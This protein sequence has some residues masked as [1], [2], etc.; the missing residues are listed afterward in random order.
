MEVSYESNA[1]NEDSFIII[2]YLLQAS[3]YKL[4]TNMM[5]SI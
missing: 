2:I 1:L 3:Y 5:L 4:S